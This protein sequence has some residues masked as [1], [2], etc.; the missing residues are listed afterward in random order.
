MIAPTPNK[1]SPPEGP[2]GRGGA[3]ECRTAGTGGPCQ[4]DHGY[5]AARGAKH[6]SGTPAAHNHSPPL[7]GRNGSRATRSAGATTPGTFCAT[8]PTAS[9]DPDRDADLP[10]GAR[11]ATIRLAV[12][13][14]AVQLGDLA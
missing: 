8:P 7:A 3:D 1:T 2:G 4:D 13:D 5:Q 9:R 10:S 11:R 6:R 14:C 12:R